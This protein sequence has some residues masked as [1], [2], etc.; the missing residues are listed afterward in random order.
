[1]SFKT[2]FKSLLKK[3]SE[4][5][6]LR[7]AIRAIGKNSDK[8]FAAL[9][10]GLASTLLLAGRFVGKGRMRTLANVIDA[11]VFLVSLSLLIKQ[12][13][14]DRPE[15]REFFSRVWKDISKT[16]QHLSAVARDYVEKRLALKNQ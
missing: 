12:N 3:L 7:E 15:V 8:N 6:K 11:A 1:M 14:F 2:E 10:Q 4:D 5:P 9:S 16:A 13:V